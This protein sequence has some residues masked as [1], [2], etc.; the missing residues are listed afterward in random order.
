MKNPWL[1]IVGA[2]LLWR[3]SKR[4]NSDEM[5]LSKN[6]RL[7]EFVT[8]EQLAKGVTFD[9]L[10]AIKNLVDHVLQPARDKTGIAIRVT[11]GLRSPQKAA[12]L[13]VPNSQHIYGMAAD[14]QPVPGTRD[15]Y[16]KLWDAIT[17]GQYDQLIWENAKAYSGTPSHLHV[18]YVGAP[19]SIYSFNRMKKLQYLNGKY[20]YI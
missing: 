12:A 19:Q 10:D 15:N 16:K 18:S 14:I 17:A 2:L 5:Q 8:A 7:Q 13:G 6:F 1:W 9:Q 11:N 4:K 3:A 20:S